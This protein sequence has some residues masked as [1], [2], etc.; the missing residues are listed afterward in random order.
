MFSMAMITAETVC[1]RRKPKKKEVSDSIIAT[2][3]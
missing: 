3:W 2:D 1:G